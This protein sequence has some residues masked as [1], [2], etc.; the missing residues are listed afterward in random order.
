MAVINADNK[1]FWQDIANKLSINRPYVG[2]RVKVTGGRKH[3]GRMGTV[4]RH[5]YD[6]YSSAFRYGGDANMHMREMAGRYGFI[7][8]IKPDDGADNFW[9]KADQVDTEEHLAT[10]DKV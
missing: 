10:V 5:E 7:V 2:R 8:L 4:I 9:V 3:L 1:D 6:R